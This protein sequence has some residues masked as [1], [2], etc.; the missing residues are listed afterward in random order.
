MASFQVRNVNVVP[1]PALVFSLEAIQ[2]NLDRMLD[3]AGGPE[4]L[5]PHMKTHKTREITEL[6]LSRGITK[7]KCATLREAEVLAQSGAPDV[8]IAY[9]MVGPNQR[10]VCRLAQRY[11]TTKFSV[12]GDDSRVIRQLDRQAVEQEIRLGLFVDVNVGQNRTGVVEQNA[13]GFCAVAVGQFSSSDAEHGVRLRGLHLYDG[14]NTA[15]SVEERVQIAQGTLQQALNLRQ[16][17]LRD[18]AEVPELVIAGTPAFP[19]YA[20][21]SRDQNVS[22]SPGTCILHDAGYHQKYPELGFQPAAA[23]LT[24]CVSR[25]GPRL[26][27][28]D[29]GTKAICSDP[30][31]TQ[32]CVVM[33]LEDARVALHNEEHL[34]LES[35]KA[36]DW[37]PGQAAYAI[38]MHICPTVALYDAAYVVS[39]GQIA[40]NWEIA[41]RNRSVG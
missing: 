14:H 8:L 26:A 13:N 27:T 33:G 30:P 25:P 20:K 29:I 39:K 32:R 40:G 24:R 6:Y 37:E 1:S 11:P 5:R 31:A 17:L 3:I 38:P 7:H 28:F 9:P 18:G 21:L 19:S 35:E 4:R 34:V 36:G 22:L 2:S 15:V 23:V 12:L 41:A 10:L 16:R